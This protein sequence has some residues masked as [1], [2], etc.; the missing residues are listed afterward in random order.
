MQDRA[1]V[2]YNPHHQR[3]AT[4][5]I[6][7]DGSFHQ[8]SE[9][10]A[11]AEN[12]LARLKASGFY[13]SPAV[14]DFGT[15]PILSVHRAEYIRFLID[16]QE[17]LLKTPQRALFPANAIVN[18]MRESAKH[19]R[20]STDFP[21]LDDG[22]PITNG[23]WDAAYW[24]AQCALAGARLV[25]AQGGVVYA[26]CRPSGHHAGLSE[27]NGIFSE[28]GGFC[29]LNNAAIAAKDFLNHGHTVAILD[30]DAHHGNGTQGIFYSE[31][32]LVCSIHGDPR[33]GFFPCYS[34][35]EHERGISKGEGF[36]HNICLTRTAGDLKFLRALSSALQRIDDYYPDYLIVSL[37]V[38][39]LK[40]DPYGD[41][42]VSPDAL[43]IVGRLISQ[44]RLP[45]LLVQE[46]GYQSRLLGQHIDSVLTNFES[47]T[48]EVLSPNPWF[49]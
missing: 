38:D 37:G 18:Y 44:L 16:T 33:E 25:A 27:A 35:F 49:G 12:I 28:Y 47:R 31:P 11:R 5:R 32:T 7:V 23:T 19:D 22:T 26:L 21:A 42:G 17:Q 1:S 39:F 20:I 15:T 48:H 34:G 13:V 6:L 29:Y 4:D 8:T 24:S 36:N 9:L 45:T 41:L 40:G 10:P 30:I 3:H 43:E 46:G 14:E 2:I